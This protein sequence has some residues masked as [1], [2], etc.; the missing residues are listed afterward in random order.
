MI[1]PLRTHWNMSLT[2][3][4]DSNC[5]GK[6][7]QMLFRNNVHRIRLFLLTLLFF[8]L[9]VPCVE[10]RTL[11]FV[12]TDYLKLTGYLGS[13]QNEEVNRLLSG[14]SD[15]VL[16]ITKFSSN[17]YLEAIQGLQTDYY[18]EISHYE[19]I[20]AF[21]KAERKKHS[22][23]WLDDLI[24]QFGKEYIKKNKAAV[25]ANIQLLSENIKDAYYK[26]VSEKL[27]Y[28]EAILYG[29]YRNYFRM[30]TDYFKTLKPEAQGRLRHAI[31]K[32]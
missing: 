30:F 21:E 12:R 5:F 17:D 2:I 10:A 11:E 6:A 7:L 4:E 3:E 20:I 31:G 14:W 1:S 19:D 26:S 16:N 28:R 22:S 8:I 9:C 25:I 15:Y 18:N 13:D 23:K 24:E 32:P 29:V 27:I